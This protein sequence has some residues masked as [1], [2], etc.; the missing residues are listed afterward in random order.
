[1]ADFE[2]RLVFDSLWDGIESQKEVTINTLVSQIQE[3]LSVLSHSNPIILDSLGHLVHY[4]TI[5]KSKYFVD[6]YSND[7]PKTRFEHNHTYVGCLKFKERFIPIFH[8]FLS[9]GAKNRLI[10]ADLKSLARWKQY[11]PVETEKD[12]K[13]IK[14]KF[15][16]MIKNLGKADDERMKL[17]EEN[18]VW[19]HKYEDKDG[20]LRQKALINI[21]E[22]F[23]MEIIDPKEGYGF[24]VIEDS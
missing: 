15:Y 20:Y 16:L 18:P 9:E 12:K 14:D 19:L 11:S 3:V 2:N 4:D 5:K 23:E 13:F 24:K 7:C 6:R 17:L 8:L 1:M 21:Y 22:K 10:V